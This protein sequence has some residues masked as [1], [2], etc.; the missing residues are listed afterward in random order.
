VIPLRLPDLYVPGRK[1]LA[2]ERECG[3]KT[4]N[5]LREIIDVIS[6]CHLDCAIFRKACNPHGLSASEIAKLL[7]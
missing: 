2:E 6:Y 5:L 1:C 4:K 3:T 7:V